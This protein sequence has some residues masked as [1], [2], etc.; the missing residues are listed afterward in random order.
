MAIPKLRDEI[1]RELDRMPVD[2]QRQVLDLARGIS[3]TPTGTPIEKLQPL[4]GTLDDQSAREMR[5]AIEKGC[6]RVDLDGW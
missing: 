4:A 3:R 1:I 6:E 5:L 2:S